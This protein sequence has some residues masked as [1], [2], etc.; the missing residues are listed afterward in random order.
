MAY[1]PCL[2]P[3]CDAGADLC[4]AGYA[5]LGGNGGMRAYFNIVSY[6][7]Q[8]IKLNALLDD[9][10]FNG[11]AVYGSI[12]SDFYLIMYDDLARLGYFFI[13]AVFLGSKA[14]AIAA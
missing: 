13:R 11:G 6:L 1:Y 9:G 4:A 10:G 12:S 14:E 3:D 8:V 7:Y 5:C 2:P